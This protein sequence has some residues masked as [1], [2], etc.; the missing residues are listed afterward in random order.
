[1]PSRAQWPSETDQNETD[2]VLAVTAEEH[3]RKHE[4]PEWPGEPVL[5]KRER[6]YFLV[7]EYAGSSS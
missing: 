2:H 4:H 1:V 6:E 5:E 3:D 7:R